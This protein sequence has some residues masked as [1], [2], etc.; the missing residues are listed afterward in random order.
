[1]RTP[2]VTAGRG[3]PAGTGPGQPARCTSWYGHILRTA[4][5]GTVTVTFC[6]VC[7]HRPGVPGARR[8]PV[9]TAW[10]GHQYAP[11]GAPDILVCAVC[12]HT[13]GS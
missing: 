4:A 7:G 8:A 12:G 11:D 10:N 2:H 13:L 1:M 5:L 3:L 6:R 9:C